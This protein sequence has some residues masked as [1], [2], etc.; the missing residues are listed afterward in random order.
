MAEVR[1]DQPQLKLL[2]TQAD[3]ETFEY[4]MSNGNCFIVSE[5]TRRTIKE[6]EPQGHNRSSLDDLK[7]DPV[8]AH[9]RVLKYDLWVLLLPQIPAN[10]KT[11]YSIFMS[12]NSA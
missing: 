10:Y 9:E 7:R 11:R 8:G 4:R 2:T 3:K 6:R 12:S 5:D 1:Q